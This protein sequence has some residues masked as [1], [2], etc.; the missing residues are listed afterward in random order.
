MT[1]SALQICNL[2]LLNTGTS[3]FINSFDAN[4]AEAR[5]CKVLYEP[6]RDALFERYPWKFAQRRR[7]LAPHAADAQQR[8]GWAYSYALPVDC[9][10]PQRIWPGVRM[11]NAL[12]KIPFDVEDDADVGSIL[13]TDWAD[14]ELVYTARN[15]NVG[16]YSPLFVET[17]SWALAVKLCLVL[18]VKPE[19]AQRADDSLTKA[20][21]VAKSVNARGHQEDPNPPSEY[22]TAR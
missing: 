15:E 19:W 10:Q 9:I 21:L 16:T 18:P 3:L 7:V 22:T 8:S 13:L 17:L 12:D 1:T 14:A 5:A 11:P 2:A 4:T 20:L 6:T